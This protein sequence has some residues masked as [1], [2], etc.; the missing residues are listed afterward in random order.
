MAGLAEVVGGAQPDRDRP[1]NEL[2]GMED[3][4]A[5]A[6][7]LHQHPALLLEMDLQV[8]KRSHRHRTENS[9]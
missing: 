4:D 1:S 7:H 5:A 6:A 8:S 2:I 9:Q 3:R